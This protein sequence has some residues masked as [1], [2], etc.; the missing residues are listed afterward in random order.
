[1][2]SC[3]SH[4]YAAPEMMNGKLFQVS[5]MRSLLYSSV[6][7]LSSCICSLHSMFGP[8]VELRSDSCYFCSWAF[9]ICNLSLNKASLTQKEHNKLQ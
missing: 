5:Q 9:P 3:G 6:M 4:C 8:Y 2:S 7:K 1:M